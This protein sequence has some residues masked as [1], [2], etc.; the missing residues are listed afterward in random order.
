VFIAD[1]TFVPNTRD[2]LLWTEQD[3]LPIWRVGSGLRDRAS[4]AA[5]QAAVVAQQQEHRRLLYVALTRAQERLIVAGWQ[6][7]NQSGP[8]WY[9]WIEA[10]MFRLGAAR[11]PSPLLQGDVLRY[12]N[13]APC[14]PAQLSL[15]L[16]E[17]R[18]ERAA[19]S[20]LHQRAPAEPSWLRAARPSHLADD[21]DAAAPSPLADS[22]A[23]YR[24]GRIV[25]RLLQAL[26]GQPANRRDAVLARLLAD[27]AHGLDADEQRALADEIRRILAA[28][29]LAGLFGPDSRAEVPLAGVLGD[30]MVFG[31]I[32]RLAVGD[33]EVLIVDYKSD[34][35]PP[36]EPDQVPV[37]YL[38]QMAAYRAL[39]R[40]I[41]PGRAVRCGLL[42]TQGPR[43]MMLD[44]ALL[45]GG[46]P[47][48]TPS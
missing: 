3:G 37:A 6:R 25:H 39:L 11:I 48:G 27:P 12:G 47:A 24:R 1:A 46:V 14:G 19:P 29:H 40:Q 18:V 13:H 34:R 2:R 30:R 45:A 9:D 44:E 36:G 43:L 4:G 8:T 22:G 33:D 35:E 38:R 21:E 7:R 10:G 20:W 23:G 16:A 5:D 26:P 41:Y 17:R 15:A 32:D 28:P 31:Q 42:W